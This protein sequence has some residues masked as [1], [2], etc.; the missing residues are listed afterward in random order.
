MTAVNPSYV[1]IDMSLSFNT[2]TFGSATWAIVNA[3]DVKLGI[4]MGEGDVSNRGSGLE[5]KEPT[6]QGRELSFD[7]VADELD[8]VFTAMR[9][10][11]LGR[12]VVEFALAN[13]PIGTSGSSASGGTAGVA[14]SRC[15]YKIFGFERNEP[16]EGS[17]T[18][19]VT[20]KPSK[21]VQVNHPTENVL[22]T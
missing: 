2:G 1:S 21:I 8:T 7:I 14:M 9:T 19:S 4:T 18:V 5:L 17:V 13:G 10:A 22:I 6:L 12:T 20:C 16:L 3:R 15:S 11:F